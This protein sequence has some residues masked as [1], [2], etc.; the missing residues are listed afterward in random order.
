MNRV[1]LPLPFNLRQW[2]S[3]Y[4]RF[5]LDN[6]GIGWSERVRQLRDLQKWIV[7]MK[8]K[9]R[10]AIDV[11]GLA[12]KVAEQ[13]LRDENAAIIKE[14]EQERLAREEARRI[15][16]KQ[17]RIAAEKLIEEE[18]KRLVEKM[19]QEIALAREEA[20][21]VAQAEIQQAKTAPV[22]PVVVQPEVTTQA[23]LPAPPPTPAVEFQPPAVITPVPTITPAPAFVPP[24]ATRANAL[25]LIAAAIGAFFLMG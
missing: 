7:I 9:I 8:E 5:S 15:Q 22:A 17:E 21:R 11:S 10:K 23:P 14:R 1:H 3:Q 2:A 16:I 24:P 25:P 19:K 13:S 6:T 20:M 18:R 12:V 4:A